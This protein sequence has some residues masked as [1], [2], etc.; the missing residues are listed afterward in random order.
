MWLP[1]CSCVKFN[2]QKRDVSPHE[3]ENAV[4]LRQKINEM[5]L[6]T[7]SEVEGNKNALCLELFASNKPVCLGKLGETIVV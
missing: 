7:N 6:L 5:T 1:S 4:P 2:E 3:K